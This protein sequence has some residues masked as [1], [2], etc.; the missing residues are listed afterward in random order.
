VLRFLGILRYEYHMTVRRWGMWVAYGLLSLL[1]FLA[2]NPNDPEIVTRDMVWQ[3]AGQ[4]VFYF[5]V[6]MPIIGGIVAAD[7]L[8]RDGHLGLR[9]L[10]RSTPLSRWAYVLG[11]YCG[12][13]L[14]VLTPIFLLILA[15]S[16]GTLF[17]NHAPLSILPAAGVAFLAMTVP[18][19]AF[20]TAFSLA[21]PLVMPLRVY[22]VL[23]TG[24]WFWGNFLDPEVFPTLNGTLLTPGGKFAF[25]GF[26]GG[27]LWAGQEATRYAVRD[28][29]LN[30]IVLALCIGAVLVCLER[31]Q[32]WQSQ[33]V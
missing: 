20:V 14:A 5:N 7:R 32:N 19:Y 21:C 8:H 25:E 12:T 18:A 17:I 29:V 24:Y 28:A 23:F 10:Q 26:F 31:Y 1:I 15:L 30:L 3:Y 9:E 33:R 11:K 16:I 4:T 22:Q 27:Y 2:P 6:F 13:L